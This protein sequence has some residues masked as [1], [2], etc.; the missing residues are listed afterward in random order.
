MSKGTLFVIS[1]ASGVGK[2]TVL[3]EVMARRE[4]LYFSVS[5]TTRDPR[6]GEI[7]GVSYTYVSKEEF[8][9]MIQADAFVEYDNHMKHFY[10]TPR[11]QLEEKL[12]QGNVILDVEPMGAFQV[13]KV[14][15]DANLIFIAPPSFEELERRLRS[16]GDTSEEQMQGRLERAHWEMEQS[17]RYD[18]VVI[19]DTVERCTEEIL[20][21]IAEKAD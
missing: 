19:N 1:G 8:E 17:S 20:K 9:G 6:P 21:F 14:R 5:A 10:G 2:S 11:A 18:L 3:K 15:P 7:P 13:R 16:R 12:Q 4:D